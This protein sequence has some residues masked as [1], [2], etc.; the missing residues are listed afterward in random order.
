MLILTLA[1]RTD[2]DIERQYVDSQ[3]LYRT[4]DEKTEDYPNL[5]PVFWSGRQG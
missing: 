1:Y 5:D 3:K 2:M 4:G